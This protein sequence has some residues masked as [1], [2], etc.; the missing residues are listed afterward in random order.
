MQVDPGDLGLQLIETHRLPVNEP[1]V[2]EPVAPQHV[3]EAIGEDGVGP[4]AQLQ[5]EVGPFGGLGPERVDHHHRAAGFPQPVLVLVGGRGGRVGTPDQDRGGVSRRPGVEA[6]ERGSVDVLEGGMAGFVAD[7]VRVDLRRAQPVEETHREVVADHGERAGVVRVQHRGA[8][9][10]AHDPLQSVGDLLGRL[11][12]GDGREVAVTFRAGPAQGMAE[13]GLRIR[14]DAV[15]GGG[16]LPAELSAAHG[17]VLV[18]AHD[19]GP[20]APLHDDDAAGV[21]AVA[22]AGGSDD[23]IQGGRSRQ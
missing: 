6:V 23:R 1:P 7:R 13:P 15:V 8:A 14:Q 21:V 16:A 4:R 9:G 2:D 17:V 3:Q 12:P 19:R 11:L 18:P 10:L 20:P 5:V 22:R